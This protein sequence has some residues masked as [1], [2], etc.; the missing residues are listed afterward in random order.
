MSGGQTGVD[1]AAL[2]VANELGIE[3]GGWCS[4]GRLAEDGAISAD[5]PFEGDAFRRL[6][7]TNGVERQGFGRNF[8]PLLWPF[9]RRD[10]VDR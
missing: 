5:Y 10:E 1:R 7:P 4:L 3:R 8:D 6:S 9:N 2:D